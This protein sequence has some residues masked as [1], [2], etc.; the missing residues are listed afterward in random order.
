MRSPSYKVPYLGIKT[1]RLAVRWLHELVSDLKI[2]MS[3]FKVPVDILVYRVASKLGI[4]DPHVDKYYGEDSPADLKIQSFAKMLFPTNPW[5]LDEPLWS[6]G[7]QPSEGGHCFPTFPN[8]DGCIFEKICPKKYVDFDPS[9][10]GIDASSKTLYRKT[11]SYVA[12]VRVRKL[13]S[14]H[15]RFSNFVQQLNEEGITGEEY[16]HKITRWF[17]NNPRKQTR[18]LFSMYITII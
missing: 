14:R 1:S 8:H 18:I 16:R 15:K 6:S 13:M 7:R 17:K 12:K 10:I 11:T 5:F 9:K 2:N 3:D 4:I